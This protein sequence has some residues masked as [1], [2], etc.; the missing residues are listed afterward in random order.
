MKVE[1]NFFQFL[2]DNLIQ[3]PGLPDAGAWMK[4]EKNFFQFLILEKWVLAL[5]RVLDV[6]C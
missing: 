6:G 2:K 1:K 5:V 3:S 4:V